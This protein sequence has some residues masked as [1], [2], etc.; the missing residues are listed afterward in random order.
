MPRTR[1]FIFSNDPALTSGRNHNIGRILS[2]YKSDG[3]F[4]TANRTDPFTLLLFCSFHLNV[5]PTTSPSCLILSPSPSTYYSTSLHSLSLFLLS[6][7]QAGLVPISGLSP[8]GGAW[9]QSLRLPQS[10][11]RHAARAVVCGSHNGAVGHATC[12]FSG[13]ASARSPWWRAAPA[14]A[15]SGPRCAAP[16]AAPVHGA[17]GAAPAAACVSLDT[18]QRRDGS[19]KASSRDDEETFM[20]CR[21]ILVHV[22]T[23]CSTYFGRFTRM[24]QVF[25]ADVGKVY[26]DVSMLRDV[27]VVL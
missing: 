22:A 26:L 1:V 19:W 23:V 2:H 13:D 18:E 3:S 8:G 14:S 17:R 24:L 7:P 21:R 11:R 6:L 15:R 25:C 9:A 20:V 12:S 27:A 16:T 10:S 4:P 5:G